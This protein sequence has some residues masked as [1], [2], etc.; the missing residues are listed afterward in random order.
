LGVTAT[1]LADGRVL[2][3][4]G[5][6]T[7][8]ELYEPSTGAFSPTGSMT[9]TRGGDTATLLPDGRV[10]FAGGYNCGPGGADGIWS[11]AELYDPATG[12]FGRTGSMRVPREFHTA[13]LLPDGTVLIAG[14]LTGTEPPAAGGI[15]FASVRAAATDQV[16]TSA[17]V[18][19]PATGTFRSTGQMVNP[20]MRH[21]ATA[22]RDG[23]VLIVGGGGESSRGTAVAELYDPSTGTFDPTGSLATVRR[24]H[25]A[26]LLADGR[27]LVA[28]GRA[29]DDAVY[30]TAELYDPRSGTFSDGGSMGNRRQQH[31]ATRLPDGR[32]L[33]TGGYA[34]N[35][36]RWRILSEVDL[37]DPATGGFTPAGSMGPPRSGHTA[38]LLLDGRVLIAGGSDATG[39]VTSAV[40]YQP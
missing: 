19:D 1:L 20:H 36:E 9:A 35:G 11:S 22:L 28:G 39:G 4:E 38:T 3:T 23:R 37:F 6:G 29:P 27:V 17:E 24:L 33:I 31:T 7:A 14:G 13:T 2:V 12:T 18:Y 16:L 30:R 15:V 21:T 25:T 40:L 10:L 26:T 34:S 32:V 8:A 5:C